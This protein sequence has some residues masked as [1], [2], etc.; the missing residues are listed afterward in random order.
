MKA[1][2]ILGKIVL[3]LTIVGG[4]VGGFFYLKSQKTEAVR[5]PEA[6]SATIVAVTRATASDERVSIAAMGTVTQSA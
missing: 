2:K 5:K 3:F 1:L 6:A 4:G